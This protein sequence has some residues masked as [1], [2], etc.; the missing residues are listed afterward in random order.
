[1]FPYSI[2]RSVQ[3]RLRLRNSVGWPLALWYTM[4]PD[5]TQRLAPLNGLSV[6]AVSNAQTAKDSR[7]A[8]QDEIGIAVHGCE[9][10]GLTGD[11]GSEID[12]VV[13]AAGI[14]EQIG[15]RGAAKVVV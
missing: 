11:V 5:L 7:D 2:R 13:G 14:D 4:P 1:M 3:G 10:L 12:R 6:L 9:E 8:V 15:R